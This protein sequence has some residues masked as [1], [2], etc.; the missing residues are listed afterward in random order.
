MILIKTVI[1]NQIVQSKKNQQKV[2]LKKNLKLKQK[3][4]QKERK[5]K[6]K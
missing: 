5:R 1:K 2:I 4:N 6:I 3:K